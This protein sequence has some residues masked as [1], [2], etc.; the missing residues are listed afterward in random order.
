MYKTYL[1]MVSILFLL[2]CTRSTEVTIA[3]NQEVRFRVRIADNLLSRSVGLMFRRHM[4]EDEGMLFLYENPEYRSFWMKQTN[5]PLDIIFINK[6]MKI[7][8]IEEADPCRE[9]PCKRYHSRGRA[10]YVLEINKG[11][12][13]KFG[14]KKGAIVK[15]RVN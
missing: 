5:I 6:E 13:K 7:I 9:S 8:N 11:L 2:G 4:G 14:F 15:S 12:S 1:L 3:G 10:R